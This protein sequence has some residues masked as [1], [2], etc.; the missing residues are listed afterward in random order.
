M[1]SYLGH[2]HILTMTLHKYLEYRTPKKIHWNGEKPIWNTIPPTFTFI[3]NPYVR[4]QKIK[5][6]NDSWI[7]NHQHDLHSKRG[8]IRIQDHKNRTR[9]KSYFLFFKQVRLDTS[10]N[11]FSNRVIENWNNLPEHVVKAPTTN[12][13]KGR[14]NDHWKC[15][16]SPSLNTKN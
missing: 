1:G 9:D 13:V 8:H 14:L 4:I 10:K 15:H 2:F 3:G 5:F 12:I 16:P 6:R 7:Q 11:T